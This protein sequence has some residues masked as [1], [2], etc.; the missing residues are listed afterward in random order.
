MS[1]DVYPDALVREIL[2]KV[3]TIAMIGASQ[4]SMRPSHHVMAFLLS[5]GYRVIPVNPGH[6]G[7]IMQGE[8]VYGRLADI[9]EPVDMVDVFR[10]SDHLMAVVDEVLAMRPTPS[11]I[12]AQLGVVDPAAAQKAEAA[13]LTM[14]MNRCP[15][16]EYPRLIT[17]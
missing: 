16:I 11:V 13:G 14:I 3:R 2:K 17:L 15:A 4:N 1:V 8:R 10:A 5:A 9:A 7:E 6:A 12:W